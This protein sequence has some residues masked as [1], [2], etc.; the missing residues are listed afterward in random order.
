MAGLLLIRV[1][2]CPVTAVISAIA[3]KSFIETL[4]IISSFII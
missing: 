3:I 2:W 4:E 1:F